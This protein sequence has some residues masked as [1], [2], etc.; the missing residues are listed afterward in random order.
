MN[1]EI[2][3][4]WTA[5]LRSG[6][7]KQGRGQLKTRS[8]NDGYCCLGV[9]CDLYDKEL[10]QT[11]EAVNG[12]VAITYLG[13]SSFLPPLVRAW[14]DIDNCGTFDEDGRTLSS[15]NDSGATF[16]E[17]ADIIDEYL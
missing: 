5:A 10:W 11:E 9:L 16:A 14:A 13:S 2:K 17:I 15:E 12:I 7:Y 6:E 3:A 4:K 1:Q 8:P